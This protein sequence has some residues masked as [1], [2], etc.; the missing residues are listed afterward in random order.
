MKRRGFF[1]TADL[2]KCVTLVVSNSPRLLSN[3]DNERRAD[4]TPYIRGVG[5]PNV[6]LIGQAIL[7]NGF[8]GLE[9]SLRRNLTKSSANAL[10]AKSAS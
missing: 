1:L 6:D 7:M 8:N 10:K 9:R 2:S 5:V 3:I 4:A